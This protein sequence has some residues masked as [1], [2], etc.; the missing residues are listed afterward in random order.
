MQAKKH[1]E[2]EDHEEILGFSFVCFVFFVFSRC[3]GSS[4][5][6]GQFVFGAG[7]VPPLRAG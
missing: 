3:Y 4:R 2:H 1:E 7:A 6:W 5:R